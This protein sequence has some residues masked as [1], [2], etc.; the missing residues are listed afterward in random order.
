VAKETYG[1][2]GQAG[3]ITALEEIERLTLQAHG[4]G[5]RVAELETTV[6]QL[7]TA[8]DSRLV[9]ERANGILAERFDLSIDDGF[10][11]LRR[12]ARTS[13]R[14]LQALARDVVESP[15]QF[16]PA[17]IVNAIERYA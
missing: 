1:T 15:R 12:A 5:Q 9:I 10:A 16:S 3:P 11:L 14:P 4:Q 8:L 2:D 17:E 13:R 7:Q 6:R